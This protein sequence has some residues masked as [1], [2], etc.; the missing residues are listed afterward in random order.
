MN[1]VN[2]FFCVFIRIADIVCGSVGG[3]CI[4]NYFFSSDLLKD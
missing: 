1:F 4:N 2:F 3:T